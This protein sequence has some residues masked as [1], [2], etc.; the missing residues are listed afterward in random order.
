MNRLARA[1]IDRG[2]GPETI[3]GLASRGRRS[4]VAMYAVTMAGGAYLPIDPDHP[5]DRVA[6]IVDHSAPALVLTSGEAPQAL[7]A[8]Q[9]L[10]ADRVVDVHSLD[11]GGYS[12]ASV[13]D[14]E[15]LRTLRPNDIAYVIYTSGRPV[16]RRV[17]RSRTP[18][19][20]TSSTG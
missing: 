3:V 4:R 1:L 15:R 11:L 17:S 10:D 8:A 13:A 20:S 5:A 12:G 16:A 14:F 7:S 9:T 2:V 18:R 19:S 6:Y